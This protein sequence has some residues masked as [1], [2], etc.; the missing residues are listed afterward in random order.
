MDCL[1]FYFF[2]FFFIVMRKVFYFVIK[3]YINC[4]S[5]LEDLKGNELYWVNVFLK[6]GILLNFE[7]GEED[8]RVISD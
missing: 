1:I 2:D 5:Y 7:W 8:K 6:M 4:L 3:D